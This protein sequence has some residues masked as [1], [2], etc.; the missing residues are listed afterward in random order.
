MLIGCDPELFLTVNG[1]LT[2]CVGLMPGTKQRPF[3][4]P[5]A[6]GLKV[7][8][9]GVT[10]EFNVAP[11]ERHAFA[12]HIRGSLKELS[13]FVRLRIPEGSWQVQATARFTKAELNSEQAM[14]LG[15]DPDCNAWA[16]GRQRFPPSIKQIRND[17]FAGGHLHFGYDKAA[18][19]VPP[20]ALIQFIE[21][22]GYLPVLPA[23]KQGRRRLFY[24]KP[25]LYREKEYGVEYRTPSNFWLLQP[26]LTL[27]M[28]RA[29]ESVVKHPELARQ[30]WPQINAMSKQIQRDITTETLS[31]EVRALSRSLTAA[32]SNADREN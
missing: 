6:H 3:A 2:P 30:L 16:K 12:S 19:S 29:A 8:E 5:S 22:M 21:V 20:W 18:C 10:L 15:C 24:G 31:E 28:S 9:D 23:D 32:F 14:L 11:V 7:Q 13:K 26:D 27:S 17:R 1:K 25:G 4:I